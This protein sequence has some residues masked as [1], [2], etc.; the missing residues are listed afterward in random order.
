MEGASADDI[1]LW[2]LKDTRVK[3]GKNANTVLLVAAFPLWIFFAEIHVKVPQVIM[4]QYCSKI[5]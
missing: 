3:R 2:L 5:M 1:S 4:M